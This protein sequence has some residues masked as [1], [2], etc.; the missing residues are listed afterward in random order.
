MCDLALTPRAIALGDPRGVF[1]L[2]VVKDTGEVLGAH[3][4]GSDAT[5]IVAQVAL[6]MEADID[7]RRL[8]QVFH[9]LHP[10]MA[11]VVTKPSVWDPRNI[12]YR[13]PRRPNARVPDR[14]RCAADHRPMP[15]AR[16]SRRLAGH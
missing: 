13:R 2:I 3:M 12:P 8:A 6:A 9:H 15:A 10:S 16:A 14:R 5:E 1:K 4:V 11:E 7:Y